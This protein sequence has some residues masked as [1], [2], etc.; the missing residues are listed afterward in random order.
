MALRCATLLRQPALAGLLLMNNVGVGCAFTAQ[1]T[2]QFVDRCEQAHN[3]HLTKRVDCPFTQDAAVLVLA[4][5]RQ[6]R[7]TGEYSSLRPHT[8]SG[9][10]RCRRTMSFEF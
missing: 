10:T 8:T 3:L 5:A 2:E 1:L 6:T 9:S 4:L 7:T